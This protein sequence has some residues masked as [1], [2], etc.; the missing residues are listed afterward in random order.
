MKQIKL[1]KPVRIRNFINASAYD[2]IQDSVLISVQN[3]VWEWEAYLIR[4]SVTISVLRPILRA[5]F[6]RF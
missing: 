3:A 1:G 5:D 4:D 2:F 6:A